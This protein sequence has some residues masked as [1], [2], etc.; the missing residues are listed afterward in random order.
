[1]SNDAK[2]SNIL[3]LILIINPYDTGYSCILCKGIK[4]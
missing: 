4:F 1:M 2:V 3:H